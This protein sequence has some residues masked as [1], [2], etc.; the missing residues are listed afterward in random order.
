MLAAALDALRFEHAHAEA[1]R[2]RESGE[3]LREPT[4]LRFR[5]PNE[6]ELAEQGLIRLNA[7]REANCAPAGGSSAPWCST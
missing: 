7:A 4:E 6:R 2:S 5:E 3:E 1:S